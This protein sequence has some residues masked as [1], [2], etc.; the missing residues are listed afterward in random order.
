[1]QNAHEY[2]LKFAHTAQI[3]ANCKR[4]KVGAV[5]VKDNHI[6]SSG[7]NGTPS[8]FI[9][10]LDG[11]CK[12]CEDIVIKPGENYELCISV[13]AEQNCILQAAKFGTSTAGG[14]LYTTLQPCLDCLKILTSAGIC[15]II[16]SEVWRPSDYQFDTYW[17]LAKSMN[18][19]CRL[20]EVS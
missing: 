8:G 13:H 10:C 17:G 14:V 4:R 9:N 20:E 6:I 7:Y 3:K 5:L 15:D 18:Q 19:F 12:R 16:Y 2:W 1:M 11:G